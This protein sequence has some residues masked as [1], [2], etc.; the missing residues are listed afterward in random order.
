MH[1]VTLPLHSCDRS[2]LHACLKTIVAFQQVIWYGAFCMGLGKLVTHIGFWFCLLAHALRLLLTLAPTLSSLQL[3]RKLSTQKC[4][5][6]MLSTYPSLTPLNLPYP[7]N[8]KADSSLSPSLGIEAAFYTP[9]KFLSLPIRV[10][11]HRPAASRN[12]SL[13][14]GVLVPPLVHALPPDDSPSFV[15]V[16]ADVRRSFLRATVFIEEKLGQ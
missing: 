3:S 13:T 16:D 15:L 9:G 2:S 10:A 1:R 6:P 5:S 7:N 12:G 8:R 14:V 4:T 11:K